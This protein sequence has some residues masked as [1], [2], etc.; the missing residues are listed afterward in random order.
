M[1]PEKYAVMDRIA[2]ELEGLRHVADAMGEPF[3]AYLIEMARVEA[4][5][6]AKKPNSCPGSQI[7]S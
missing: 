2:A 4:R 6:M 5:R 1:S 3:L 7:V